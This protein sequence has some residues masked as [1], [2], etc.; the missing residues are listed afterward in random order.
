MAKSRGGDATYFNIFGWL[1]SYPMALAL[2]LALLTIIGIVLALILLRRRELI[3]PRRVLGAIGSL[4]LPLLVAGIVGWLGWHVLVLFRPDFT[5]FISGDTY[6][7]MITELGFMLA[8]ITVALGWLIALRK[9]NQVEVAMAA[10]AWFGLLG[11]I[12]AVVAPGASYIF[13]WPALFGAVGLLLVP[14]VAAA[15][16]PVMATI[17]IVPAVLLILPLIWVLLPTLGLSLVL[18]PMVLIALVTVLVVP[19]A[20]AWKRRRALY[21]VLAASILLVVAGTFVDRVDTAHPQ[22]IGLVYATDA[23]TGQAFWFSSDAYANSWTDHYVSSGA[24]RLDE[25]FP[26]LTLRSTFRVGTAPVATVVS[27]QVT[28]IGST[29]EGALRKVQLRLQVTGGWANM[30]SVYV[31][32]GAGTVDHAQLDGVDLTGGRDRTANHTPWQWG[33]YINAPAPAGQDL[34]IWVKNSTAPI[35][36]KVLAQSTGL[37]ESAVTTPRP[38]TLIPAAVLSDMS[39]AA[40][41]VTG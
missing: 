27:P 12:L 24:K 8:A 32:P 26:V 1:V 23:D 30:L 37:P 29:Q 14:R 38:A 6:R 4:P 11:G 5:A 10:T 17:G 35:K 19:A 16:Q 36:V 33:M 9:Q 25:Q 13:V 18:V 28:V 39:I 34:T 40:V 31:D 21:A 22:E 15:W 7:P 3:S 41:T 2:P 20:V